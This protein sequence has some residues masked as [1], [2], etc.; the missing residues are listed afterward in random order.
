MA[1]DLKASIWPGQYTVPPWGVIKLGMPAEPVAKHHQITF[2]KMKVH[3]NQYI[4]YISP[5]LKISRQTPMSVKY[6][7]INANWEEKNYEYQQWREMFR[8]KRYEEI[9]VMI[10]IS[11]KAF[12]TKRRTY[13]QASR[14]MNCLISFRSFLTSVFSAWRFTC[15]ETSGVGMISSS[16]ATGHG[17]SRTMEEVGRR[18]TAPRQRRPILRLN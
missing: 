6:Y 11:K 15:A 8:Q 3:T 18:G 9:M 12:E 4:N 16:S 13:S 1:E 2:Q 5:H 14:K 7:Y 10:P 17:C